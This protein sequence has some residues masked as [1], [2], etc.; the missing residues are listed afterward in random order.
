MVFKGLIT[1]SHERLNFILVRVFICLHQ[2][3]SIFIVGVRPLMDYHIC[4]VH[5]KFVVVFYRIKKLSHSSSIRLKFQT[6]HQFHKLIIV[7][8]IA[9]KFQNLYVFDICRFLHKIGKFENT[10]CLLGC[11]EGFVTN[12]CIHLIVAVGTTSRYWFLCLSQ[13]QP[14]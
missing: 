11:S 4:C 13:K 14:R 7:K 3:H 8:T 2:S 10:Y 1:W 5:F 12:Q 6:N 9:W